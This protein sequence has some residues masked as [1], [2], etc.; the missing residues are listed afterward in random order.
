MKKNGAFASFFF[1]ISFKIHIY[2]HTPKIINLLYTL[3]KFY[4]TKSRKIIQKM[5][6]KRQNYR[7]NTRKKT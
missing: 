4:P 1:Q 2:N 5:Q 7:K 6:V 3:L